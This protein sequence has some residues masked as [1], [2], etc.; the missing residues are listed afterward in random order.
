MRGSHS[1]ARQATP[2]EEEEKTDRWIDVQ[3]TWSGKS[4]NLAIADTDRYELGV[5]WVESIPYAR[6]GCMT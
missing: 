3:F 2:P 6:S 5:N 4:F 1:Q